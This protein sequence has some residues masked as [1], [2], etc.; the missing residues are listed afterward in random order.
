M[1]IIETQM[2]ILLGALLGMAGQVLRMVISY[3]K[4]LLQIFLSLLV[5]CTIGIITAIA[6]LGIQ[7]NELIMLTFITVGY[8]GTDFIE[9]LIKDSKSD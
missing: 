7:I 9:G 2:F 1:N 4:S 5:S 8:A 6:L 3:K